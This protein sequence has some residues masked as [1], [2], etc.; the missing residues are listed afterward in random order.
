VNAICNVRLTIA[1]LI[2]FNHAFSFS[3]SISAFKTANKWGFKQG[4]TVIIEPQYD[5]VYGFDQTNQICLVG[6]IDPLKR[7]VN[8]LT[9]QVKIGYTFNFINTKHQKLYFKAQQGLD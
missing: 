5:S 9:K 7:S 3:Q 4:Q 8:S 2:T 6:N 1:V